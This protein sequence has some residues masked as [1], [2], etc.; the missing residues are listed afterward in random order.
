[1]NHG[2][3]RYV[4][5]AVYVPYRSSSSTM[6]SYCAVS[7]CLPSCYNASRVILLPVKTYAFVALEKH[8]HRTHEKANLVSQTDYSHWIDII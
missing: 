3:T 5:V 8:V 7:S 2:A 6:P 1:M 4:D